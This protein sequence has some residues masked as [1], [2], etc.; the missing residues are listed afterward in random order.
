MKK[1]FNL[2]VSKKIGLGFIVMM[3]VL[4]VAATAGFISTSRLS[5]S[6][7]YVT[8]D[9]WN[10]ADGALKGAIAIEEQFIAT[11]EVLTAA[12]SGVLLNADEK[13]KKA[14]NNSDQ[15]FE[16]MIEA[17]QIPEQFVDETR[18]VIAHFNSERD[19]VMSI[20]KEYVVSSLAMKENAKKF[21]GFMGLVEGAG[22]GAFEN[23]SKKPEEA[24]TWSLLS[25][26]WDAADGAMKARIALLER[27]HFY[28]ELVDGKVEIK[29]VEKNLRYSLDDLK[30][31]I[32]RMS[33]LEVFSKEIPSP[34]YKGKIFK[35]VM[36]SMLKEHENKMANLIVVF[37]EFAERR[38]L[39]KANSDALLVEIEKLGDIADEAVN[40]EKERI[41]TVVNSAFGMIGISLAVG[42]VMA[43]GAI[44]LSIRVISK[45]LREV[46]ENMKEI[47]TGEGDLSVRLQVKS[48]DEIGEI[49]EGF[50]SFVTKIQNI[51]EKVAQTATQLGVTVD[52]VATMTSQSSA[53]F[54]GQQKETQQV[55]KAI[56]EMAS[57]IADVANSTGY[58]VNSANDA[59]TATQDGQVIVNTA[60]ASISRLAENV[61]NAAKVIDVVGQESNAIGTVLDVIRSIAEQT[62]LLALN[63]AIE[64]ARAGE[65]GRGFAVVA[66]E[67]RTLASRTQQS[68]EEIQEMIERLQ[69]SSAKAVKVMTK[70]R[71][72][73]EV[74]LKQV[75]LA[76]DALGDITGAVNQISELNTSIASSADEQ[77]QVAEEVNGSVVNINQLTDENVGTFNQILQA[78]HDMEM[79]AN[80]LNQL[81]GQFKV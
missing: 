42:I 58:A 14:K 17:G 32:D 33:R 5:A 47:S 50:N 74:G 26:K 15:A 6:L 40:G 77:S 22:V 3:I 55:A 37:R 60:V 64:A 80:E 23:L 28:Q 46:A 11:N 9:I 8:G 49:A 51:I 81:V 44:I 7:K 2:S 38:E 79:L 34:Q 68:T 53:T 48:T 18:N 30:Y 41:E 13:V 24:Y 63:A 29:T 62:N 16:K 54:S 75:N 73:A 65:H 59:Q 21:V 52:K 78:G 31:N 1:I 27:L 45:P 39:F 10:T 67:V 36:H 4:M 20:A 12:I 56:N 76:G 57:T 71:E 70:G 69:A 66:D 61:E 43:L 72:E 35:D 19:A 25:E